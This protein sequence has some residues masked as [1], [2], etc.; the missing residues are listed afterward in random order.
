MDGCLD[1]LRISRF[2]PQPTITTTSELGADPVH[3]MYSLEQS[4]RR[5][6]L[7]RRSRKRYLEFIKA[8]LVPRYAEFIGQLNPESLSRIL[9]RL[10]PENLF[11]SLRLLCRCP[12][13]RIRD[14]KD[15]DTG[16]LTQSRA[17]QP[18]ADQ[19]REARGHRQIRRT[20]ATRWVKFSLRSRAQ[21]GGKET[22]PGPAMK[23]SARVIEKRNLFAGGRPAFR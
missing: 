17:S 1:A 16:Q 18:G 9:F 23:R 3:L 14:F 10:R 19:D 7:P 20:S 2:S 6:Q 5:E 11:D 13:S 4:I 15:P 8:E 21:N 12:G 22:R